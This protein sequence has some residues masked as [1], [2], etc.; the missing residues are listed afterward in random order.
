MGPLAVGMQIK[1]L[2]LHT[3]AQSRP[4]GSAQTD[5]LDCSLP[6]QGPGILRALPPPKRCDPFSGRKCHASTTAG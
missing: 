5:S 6:L 4:Q 1:R 2:D 3:E